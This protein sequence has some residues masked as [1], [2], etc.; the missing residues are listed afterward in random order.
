MTLECYGL[1]KSVIKMKHRYIP[2]KDHKGFGEILVR[3]IAR[4]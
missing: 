4:I 3:F 1:R 2:L